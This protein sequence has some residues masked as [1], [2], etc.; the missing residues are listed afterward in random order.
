M[1][2]FSTMLSFIVGL[3][4]IH[5]L[6]VYYLCIDIKMQDRLDTFPVISL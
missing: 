4:C 6:H 3:S 1:M 2:L 5:R